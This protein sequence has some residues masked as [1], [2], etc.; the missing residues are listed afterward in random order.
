VT[1]ETAP[2]ESL[3]I[4]AYIVQGL[5]ELGIATIG[6]LRS[7]KDYTLMCVPGLGPK[8]LKQIRE[9]VGYT[10]DDS[11]EF[12]LAAYLETCLTNN[13]PKIKSHERSFSVKRRYVE[14]VSLAQDLMNKFDI[15][16]RS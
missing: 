2:I 6:D 9:L 12:Q 10:A 4:T 11:I 5:K 1:D 13:P 15:K 3:P 7:A 14:V 8:K 16:P